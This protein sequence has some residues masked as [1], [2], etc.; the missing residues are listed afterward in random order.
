MSLFYPIERCFYCGRTNFQ[1]DAKVLLEKE[2]LV[3]SSKITAVSCLSCTFKIE[4][5]FTMDELSEIS[6]VPLE[7]LKNYPCITD[8]FGAF[9]KDIPASERENIF[10][11]LAD[12][13]QC[14]VCEYFFDLCKRVED[15]NTEKHSEED[16]AKCAPG[17]NM[18]FHQSDMESHKAKC[19]I[20]CTVCEQRFAVDT[21]HFLNVHPCFPCPIY[22]CTTAFKRNGQEEDVHG[23]NDFLKHIITYHVWQV[24]DGSIG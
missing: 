14:Q 17:C 7:L 3:T 19:A 4:Y 21:G 10:I 22:G 12:K 18:Y 24:V 13:Y 15:H 23:T 1:R 5:R 2:D 6:E 11:G 9:F 8:S 16:M 20:L